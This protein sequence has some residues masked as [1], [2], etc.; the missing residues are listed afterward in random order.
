MKVI[1]ETIS[2]YLEILFHKC[3]LSG[4]FPDCFKIAEVIP[5]F[6]GGEKEDKNCYRPISLLPT[7]S[8]IFER[9]L[10]TRLISFFTKFNVLSKDQF[11]FRAKFSTEY[12]I[13]DIYD[14]LINNLDK[15]LSSCAIFL[16]L[17]KAFDSVSHEILLRKLHYY[18][19]RGKALELFKSYLSCR[20]QFVK[21]NGVKSSLARVEFGV[22]QG[23]ILGPLLF[24]IFIKIL[25]FE[26]TELFEKLFFCKK[27]LPSPL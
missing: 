20:S 24:L 14:K 11:G 13:A 7:I 23:S 4:V 15:G 18:G 22:P 2:P 3:I 25:R 26:V 21:L 1:N 5:L 17:A 27:S 19:V 10:A 6:K 16:D 8:K 12:A 9:V